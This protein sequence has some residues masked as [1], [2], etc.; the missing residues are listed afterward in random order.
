[1]KYLWYITDK[2]VYNT[3]TFK[4]VKSSKGTTLH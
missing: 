4:Y 1:M 3:G 2:I